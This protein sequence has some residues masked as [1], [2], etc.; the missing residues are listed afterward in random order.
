MTDA[1]LSPCIGSENACPCLLPRA[2]TEH[3][4]EH[5]HPWGPGWLEMYQR[6]ESEVPRSQ[7]GRLKDRVPGKKQRTTGFIGIPHL[8]LK[9]LEVSLPLSQQFR[10]NN[11]QEK[12]T[13]LFKEAHPW[14]PVNTSD[15]RR[16]RLQRV[17]QGEGEQA[18]QR[19]QLVGCDHCSESQ[20][21]ELR[22]VR[23][24]EPQDRPSAQSS[25]L[26]YELPTLAPSHSSDLRP[27]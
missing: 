19:A 21:R 15:D 22:R 13:F 7:T 25:L 3:A 20:K 12:I 5:W 18:G 16:T 26:S 11:K 9:L 10:V 24:T 1:F 17:F 8:H 14:L 27:P 6:T 2:S 23:I 4:G